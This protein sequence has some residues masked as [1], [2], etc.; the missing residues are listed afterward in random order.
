MSN[1]SVGSLATLWR[2]PVKSMLGEA[3]RH[4]DVTEGGLVGDRAY[5]LV[6]RVSGKVVSAKNVKAYPALLHCR[7]AFAETPRPGQA[8]PPVRITLPDG[9]IVDSDAAD[10]NAA[11]S[12]FF[13]RDVELRRA[14]PADYTIDEYNLDLAN[15]DLGPEIAAPLGSALWQRLGARSPVPVGA[16]FDA[17]PLSVLTT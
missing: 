1:P 8:A 6:E 17:F 14:A 13:G 5:G 2:F 16:F 9:R 4:A 12:K 15:D 10:A 11:L 7:A 3:V